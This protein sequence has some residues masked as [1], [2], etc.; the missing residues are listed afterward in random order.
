MVW[1][2]V[3]WDEEAKEVSEEVACLSQ[4]PLLTPSGTTGETEVVS[5]PESGDCIHTAA[6][7]AAHTDS[8]CQLARHQVLCR[9]CGKGEGGCLLLFSPVGKNSIAREP[10]QAPFPPARQM[11]PWAWEIHLA[12]TP[13]AG[14][15]STALLVPGEIS[16]FGY[17]Q[18]ALMSERIG[19][20][21]IARPGMAADSVRLEQFQRW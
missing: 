12:R 11:I 2:R 21:Q 13:I 6:I 9:G 10:G 17:L 1:G 7:L 8:C 4:G 15:G 19:G 20:R 3:E 16:S 18:N 5:R 14:A